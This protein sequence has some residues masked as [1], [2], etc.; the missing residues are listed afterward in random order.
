MNRFANGHSQI[1]SHRFGHSKE[2]AD[3]HYIK[4]L[5]DETNRAALA[6]DS[7]LAELLADNSGQ[8]VQ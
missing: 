5:P 7:A 4:P 2:V 8:I 3:S 1:T 6:F